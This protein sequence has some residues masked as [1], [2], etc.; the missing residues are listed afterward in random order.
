ME[1]AR[2]AALRGYS[3]TLVEKGQRLGGNLIPGGVPDFKRNDRKLI[4]WY[5]AQLKKLG[6]EVRAEMTADVAFVEDFAPDCVV[7]ATG[8]SPIR[9]A[10]GEENIVCDAAEL[11]LGNVTAGQNVIVAGG[12]LVGC[13]TALWLAQQGK[14]VNVVEREGDILGGPHGMPMMN[15]SMLREL[16]AFHGVVIHL[17]AKLK[18]VSNGAA[19]VITGAGLRSIPADTAVSA[20]GYRPND[21]LYRSLDMLSVPVYNIGDS[22]T[23]KNIM[24]AIWS[25]YEVARSI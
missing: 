11:L 9:L 16:L 25:A 19:D 5:E 14:T 4:K 18:R 13:E 24:R 12:G 3:V 23:V 10:L 22:Q 20:V 2:V 1:A 6:V 7:T 15:S 17:N 21:A 8:G